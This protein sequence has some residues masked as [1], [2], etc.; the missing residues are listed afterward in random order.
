M[1]YERPW[2][3]L[4][5]AE[6][7]QK[8]KTTGDNVYS[9]NSD[10]LAAALECA[11]LFDGCSI[12]VPTVGGYTRTSR[13]L[14][15]GS[16]PHI[17]R[18]AHSIVMGA[19]SLMFCQ[20]DPIGM[21]TNN[22][23]GW[24]EHNQSVLIN[25]ALSEEYKVEQGQG[26]FAS[27]HA[28]HR[29]GGLLALAATGGY[30]A[31][32]W[33]GFDHPEV[34]LENTLNVVLDTSGPDAPVLGLTRVA[35]YDPDWFYD[36]Q[37]AFGSSLTRAAVERNTIDVTDI[38]WKGAAVSGRKRYDH[39]R[40]VIP[41]YQAW[42]NKIAG[43][44]GR[45]L[46][47]LPKGEVCWDHEYSRGEIFPAWWRFEPEL[48]GEWSWPLTQ[49]VFHLCARINEMTHD[50]DETQKKAPQRIIAATQQQINQFGSSKGVKFLPV[51]NKARDPRIIHAEMY[52]KDAIALIDR[53]EGWADSDGGQNSN[54]SSGGSGEMAKSGKHEHL[55]ASYWT[56]RHADPAQAAVDCIAIQ[57]SRRFVWALQ[58]MVDQGRE[59]K[60]FWG[61]EGG[62]REEITV[63]DLDLD[64]S[65]Y[66]KS[67]QAVSDKSNSPEAK[68][69]QL[70][71]FFERGQIDGASWVQRQRDLDA[72]HV[73]EGITIQKKWLDEQI[74][75]W[76]H[77]S[78]ESQL[79]SD[80]YQSPRRGMDLDMLADHAQSAMLEAE[81]QGMGK[82]EPERLEY[83]ELFIDECLYFTDM[84]QAQAQA[85]IK[86]EAPLN[87][88]FPALGAGPPATPGATSGG[89][90]TSIPAI[91]A[92]GAAA[93]GPGQLA[94]ISGQGQAGGLPA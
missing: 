3:R 38:S 9:V 71:E 32:T 78:K 18:K 34:E 25:N 57:Q 86:T 63:N 12:T 21:L 82:T 7:A 76:R 35:Y 83:F 73:A 65:R 62:A 46:G 66:A 56:E 48:F 28:L 6:A 43:T 13:V 45:T 26:R 61:P 30:M 50:T 17:R 19:H 70:D 5:R 68:A 23:G 72:Q 74:R 81:M 60:R 1:A 49:L 20:D 93:I 33:P 69:E 80:F 58:E 27:T 8:V 75:K 31:F 36:C 77:A 90:A 11:S 10:R 89:P 16:T 37:E 42:R 39:R 2:H 59:I 94:A 47:V 51:E 53:Y 44:D 24:Q 64:E 15:G 85:S 40:Q 54:H 84:D 91:S 88:L 92:P 67:I 4:G 22:G 29:K 55:R 87:S 14:P 79:E 52:N 41:V